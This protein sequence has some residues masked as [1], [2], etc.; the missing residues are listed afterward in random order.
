MTYNHPKHKM[1]LICGKKMKRCPNHNLKHNYKF[2]CCLDSKIS[3]HIIFYDEEVRLLINNCFIYLNPSAKTIYFFGNNDKLFNK[4]FA[5]KD[6]DIYDFP[7][8]DQKIKFEKFK[9]KLNVL[10]K[11]V[12]RLNYL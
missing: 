10:L 8:K 3:H 5:L 7:Y 4:F 2:E 1:C 6:L 12:K 11:R 9:N